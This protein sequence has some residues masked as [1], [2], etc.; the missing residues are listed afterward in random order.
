MRDRLRSRFIRVVGLLA[1]GLTRQR[2]SNE[3]VALCRHAI[4]IEP[5]AE[6]FHARLI[7]CYC[8][9]GRDAEALAAY[10][11]CR[12]L[13]RGVLGVEPSP[14][15]K[16]LGRRLLESSRARVLNRSAKHFS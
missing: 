3:I 13:L 2:S 9:E 4:E 12:E 1:D 11:R 10:E 8:A 7:Q 5:T 16:A 14:A 6:E 15:T